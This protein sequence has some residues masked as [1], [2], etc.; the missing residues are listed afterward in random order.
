MRIRVPSRLD[1]GSALCLVI[2]VS[3]LC[4]CGPV[5]PHPEADVDVGP[6]DADADVDRDAEDAD[7][8]AIDADPD[9]DP[10]QD[11]EPDED[12]VTEV[13]QTTWVKSWHD[14]GA[15]I[16]T[17]LAVARNGDILAAGQSGGFI[18]VGRLDAFG[19]TLWEK[20]YGYERPAREPCANG[21]GEVD[22][23]TVFVTG[24]LPEHEGLEAR[25]WMAHLGADGELLEQQY[26][27]GESWRTCKRGRFQSLEGGDFML[28]GYAMAMRYSAIDGVRWAK[29]YSSP[30]GGEVDVI[31]VNARTGESILG[32][33]DRDDYNSLPV[34]AKTDSGGEILW[35]VSYYV[36]CFGDPEPSRAVAVED[37]LVVISP[38]GFYDS[39]GDRHEALVVMRLT[40]EGVLRWV[41][42]MGGNDDLV[43]ID[44]AVLP[45][46]GLALVGSANQGD[47]YWQWAGRMD[48]DTGYSV[49]QARVA[50]TE[51]FGSA[52]AFAGAASDNRFIISGRSSAF[53]GTTLASLTLDGTIV[54]GCDWIEPD[55]QSTEECTA[56]IWEP[57]E[58][59]VTD[60]DVEL[61]AADLVEHDLPSDS[62]FV[63]P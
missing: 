36:D 30:S 22:D 62:E 12:P 46:G 23:G 34:V 13:D 53:L 2:G 43:P 54:G 48:L 24:Y 10:D 38:L 41:R 60:V 61:A 44:A 49:W 6:S 8:P 18:W 5:R 35:A 20:R 58:I 50:A 4:S 51:G 17:A 40:D 45:P 21:V 26:G 63:C 47:A 25:G 59:I 16:I 3:C 28:G 11:P 14:Y 55:D 27:L 9:L 33:Q 37:G 15:P 52:D 7:R 39:E 57:V 29:T 1:L 56:T 32:Y 42:S 19:S 31:G